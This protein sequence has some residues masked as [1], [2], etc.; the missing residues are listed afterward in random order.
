M[1]KI[2][3]LIA[4]ALAMALPLTISAQTPDYYGYENPDKTVLMEW[5][6]DAI[7]NNNIPFTSTGEKDAFLALIDT[8]YAKRDA[9]DW[10]GCVTVAGYLESAAAN[11]TEPAD[12]E[13][14]A[15]LCECTGDVY[16]DTEHLMAIT[17]TDQGEI[18]DALV[19]N[20]G[21]NAETEEVHCAGCEGIDIGKI[22]I[23][24]VDCTTIRGV[25]K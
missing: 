8:L 23:H 13:L 15:S 17:P 1:K 24:A 20:G 4:V 21:G 11:I 14:V 5:V 19:T 22:H 9:S 12:E 25:A 10:S 18:Q 2:I 6:E 7:N 3:P 16:T